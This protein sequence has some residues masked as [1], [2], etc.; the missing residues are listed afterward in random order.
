MRKGIAI[1]VTPILTALGITLLV[2]AALALT[3][4][5]V[6]AERRQPH[7]DVLGFV[8]A[9]VGV[10]YAVVLALV[11]I[12]VWDAQDQ[13]RA[14]T[15]TETDALLQITWYAST[16][17]QPAHTQIHDLAVAYTNTVIDDE[18][19]LL[20]RHQASPAAW[21]L[22]TRLRTAIATQ[23]A[24]TR[25]DQVRYQ[26]AYDATARLGDARRERLDQA[27]DGV[28]SLIWV[29]LVFGGAVTVAYAFM[30]GMTSLTAHLAVVASLTLLISSLL[31]IVYELGYPFTG[32]LKIQPTAFDLA[33][34]RM[35]ALA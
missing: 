24:A 12:G 3:S 34:Q 4:R 33:L 14:N 30:F 13:A 8:Y 7:N 27:D 29:A 25:A 22:F 6:P 31:L 11:V 21:D 16:L 32:A 10:V 17:P 15:Y 9:V 5:Y 18:W 1:A 23:Q 2:T 28:P 19:P 26:Q 35:N 20:A